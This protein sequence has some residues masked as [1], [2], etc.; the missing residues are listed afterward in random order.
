MR[1]GQAIFL[2]QA[3]VIFAKRAPWS[4]VDAW[5]RLPALP[6]RAALGPILSFLVRRASLGT[7]LT[8]LPCNGG[9]PQ[10]VPSGGMSAPQPVQG[11]RGPA[12]Q[13]STV[14]PAAQRLSCPCVQARLIGFALYWTL[15]FPVKWLITQR[16]PGAGAFLDGLLAAKFREDGITQ[17]LQRTFG[18]RRA[19]QACSCCSG[20]ASGGAWAALGQCTGAGAEAGG[21]MGLVTGQLPCMAHC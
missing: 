6:S 9:L 16:F 18:E 2:E 10:P 15:G 19:T 5:V 7:P 17:V 1:A 12:A 14:A 21:T 11:S 20:A 8:P 3:Q 4:V 13:P